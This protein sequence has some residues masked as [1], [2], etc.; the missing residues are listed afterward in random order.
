MRGRASP[1]VCNHGG[2]IDIVPSSGSTSRSRAIVAT[3]ALH[4]CPSEE[5]AHVPTSTFCYSLLLCSRRKRRVCRDLA[6]RAAGHPGEQGKQLSPWTPGT[7][8]Q[9]PPSL[10]LPLA[11]SSSSSTSRCSRSGPRRAG[12]RRSLR[13]Q[14]K[15]WPATSPFLPPSPNWWPRCY[16]LHGHGAVVLA[17]PAGRPWAALAFQA[18]HCQPLR[19]SDALAG[20]RSARPQ[21]QHELLASACTQYL[22]SLSSLL[23][24][25]L[26]LFWYSLS[27]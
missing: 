25:P 11:S 26:L 24:S 7:I 18:R 9:L 19:S 23:P 22:M 16:C 12:S 1:N 6:A 10:L 27:A 21:Y 14:F 4:A 15:A 5:R 13:W 17:A 3:Q 20:R 8:A 2:Q